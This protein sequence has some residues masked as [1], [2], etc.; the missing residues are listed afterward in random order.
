MMGKIC[1]K[2]GFE[3]GVKKS[4]SAMDGESGDDGTDEPD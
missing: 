4:R 1:E 2:M 3:F